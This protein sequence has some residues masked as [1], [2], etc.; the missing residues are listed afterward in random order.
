M[1]EK[2]KRILK[3]AAFAILAVFLFI[4]AIFTFVEVDEINSMI[5][6][7]SELDL[8]KHYGMIVGIGLVFLAGFIATTIMAIVSILPSKKQ[9]KNIDKK[10]DNK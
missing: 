1:N 2:M 8:I 6:N 10:Q 3:F 9:E 5:K 7:T 4:A